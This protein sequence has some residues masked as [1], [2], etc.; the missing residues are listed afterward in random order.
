MTF[1]HTQYL[2]LN[3][4]LYLSFLP[5]ICSCL[6]ML[7]I[8]YLPPEL[9]ILITTALSS[10]I[11][12]AILHLKINAEIGGWLT[13]S[14]FVS[15]QYH[16][17]IYLVAPIIF[18]WRTGLSVH[19]RLILETCCLLRSRLQGKCFVLIPYC[20]LHMNF[21]R[22]RLCTVLF[23]ML[24]ICSRCRPYGHVRRFSVCHSGLTVYSYFF[25]SFWLQV[26]FNLIIIPVRDVF[27][28]RF[29]SSSGTMSMNC[30]LSI[31]PWALLGMS[32]ILLAVSVLWIQLIC[33]YRCTLSRLHWPMSIFLKPFID[34]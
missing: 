16:F 7:L 29:V 2:F 26:F 33:D 24:F 19:N 30:M 3:K 21:C 31:W 32:P 13:L 22:L 15:Y 23:C 18:V 17:T 10:K 8:P 20:S 6:P 5:E 9:I 12:F 1:T 34:P 28:I 14:S 25:Q 4:V 27:E 11:G